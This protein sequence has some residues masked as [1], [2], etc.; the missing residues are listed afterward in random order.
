MFEQAADTIEDVLAKTDH[1]ITLPEA[2]Q[3]V[4]YDA[5]VAEQAV[6]EHFEVT[7]ARGDQWVGEAEYGLP[8]R[9]AADA[10]QTGGDADATP[11][12]SQTVGMQ[13]QPASDARSGDVDLSGEQ[14]QVYT[15][16]GLRIDVNPAE[17]LAGEPTGDDYMGA[18][19]LVNSHPAVPDT[20]I[21]YY[22][23]EIGN[24]E[25]DTEDLFYRA[26]SRRMPVLLEGEAGTGKN[27]LADAAAS[28]LNLPKYREEF[29]ADTSV[30][31]VI[32]EKDL[33]G[34]DETVTILGSA[35]KA[36]MFGGMFIAD[37]I[38]M[39]TGSIT[40]YLH[41]LFESK[42]KRELQLRGTGRTLRDLPP[43]VEWDP[44]KHLGRYIHPD[45][46]A[47]GTC[48]PI[49]YSDT[50]P[51]NDALRDRCM[52]IGHP[53]LAESEQDQQGMKQEALLVADETDADPTDVEDLVRC[54]VVLREMHSNRE[55]ATP[56]GHRPIRDTVE[57][58]GPNEEFM[59]FRGAALIKMCGQ[60]SSE[61]DRDAIQDAIE[62]EL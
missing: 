7:E 41:P 34:G 4:D 14:R 19:K 28:R 18:R 61:A 15:V 13:T 38:N 62:D 35:A 60:A 32:A 54:A 44:E 30:M 6:K 56:I 43:D 27:Q 21:P 25:R 29:G 8:A 3:A 12:E 45:F 37:E 47:V 5:L 48:N 16:N 24:G 10:D 42:G 39:A 11:S 58:A 17:A 31:D 1:A 59:S 9:E 52:V 55:I 40:S 23:V 46:Y 33:A 22:P 2:T 36:A 50:Q 49:W 20:E 57:L 26:L 51:M 53:Y